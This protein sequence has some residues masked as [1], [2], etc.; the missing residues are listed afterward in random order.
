MARSTAWALPATS[1]PRAKVRVDPEALKSSS[2]RMRRR[3][4][5][6]NSLFGISMPT[7]CLPGIGRLD[8]ERARGERH[9]QVVG[10]GLDPAELDIRRRL[11]FVLG[12]DRP[13]V[14]TDDPDRDAEA[15]QLL[16]DDVLDQQM[17]RLVAAC[18]KRDRDVVED[19]HRWQ[20]VV[21]AV[22]GLR[23]IGPV[24]DVVEIAQRPDEQ[25]GRGDHASWPAW[26]GEGRGVRRGARHG[27]RDGRFVVPCAGLAGRRSGADRDRLGRLGL[28][29]RCR[30]RCC[31]GLRVAVLLG[32]RALEGCGGGRAHPASGADGRAGELSKGDAE[33]DDH[34]EDRQPD[35]QDEGALRTEE[36]GQRRRQEPSDPSAGDTGDLCGA[37]DPGVG[38]EQ[39]EKRD[40]PSPIPV[41]CPV[42]TRATSRRA[43]AGTGATQR[44]APNHGENVS[45]HQVVRA[46]SPGSVRAI[47]VIAPRTS[48]VSPMIERTTSGVS[49]AVSES[50]GFLRRAREARASSPCGSPCGG[51]SPR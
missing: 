14:S 34:P 28:A 7:A 38:D 45:R 47:S 41:S 15:R 33:P 48:S 24:G 42:P 43:A 21:D 20:D 29:V 23:R 46:P 51:G 2:S 19:H 32:R 5:T 39:P 9:R 49:R 8:P 6:L 36:V 4:T 50:S 30:C 26:R 44:I 1:R 11:D 25:R 27:R 40:H 37:G 18:M 12:D 35:H 17:R 13:R 16:D 31:G 10:Q 3:A 22:L